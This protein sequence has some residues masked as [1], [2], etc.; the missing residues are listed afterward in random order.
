MEMPE[1]KDFIQGNINFLTGDDTTAFVLVC[2]MD[3]TG[4]EE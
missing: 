4:S 2:T 1:G 3:L